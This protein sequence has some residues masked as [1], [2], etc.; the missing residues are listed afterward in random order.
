MTHDSLEFYSNSGEHPR[1]PQNMQP[2]DSHEFIFSL[3]QK[4]EEESQI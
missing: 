1:T 3:S 2:T 4:R